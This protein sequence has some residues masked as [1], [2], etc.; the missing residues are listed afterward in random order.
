M[1]TKGWHYIDHEGTFVLPGP[2]RISYLYFPLLNETG[3]VSSITPMLNGDIK[4][5]QNSFLLLPV[6]AEDLHNSRS[7]RN[8]WVKIN[9]KEIWS[10]TGNSAA[11][12]IEKFSDDQEEVSLAAGILW[13]RIT[14]AN[15]RIGLTA[16]ITNFVA[17]DD[18]VELMKVKLINTGDK[19]LT[20]EPT[21]A[22]P[23]FGRSADNVRDHRHVTS[24]LQCIKCEE[25]GV[26]VQPT[27]TFD[28][29][30]HEPNTISYG[31]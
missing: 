7:A 20:I 18:N 13:H 5:G 4:T 22:I 14:R 29:R 10:A 9:G 6:S 1:M 26:V 2:D 17:K 11:Q 12:T 27:M 30:G 16:E 25:N 8:F 31:V 23:I 28:E 3:M 15:Q 21:A 19:P 24:L